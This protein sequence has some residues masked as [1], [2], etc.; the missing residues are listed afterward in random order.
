[1]TEQN[2]PNF[3]PSE[4]SEQPIDDVRPLRASQPWE[5]AT[6]LEQSVYNTGYNAA[7]SLFENI[8]LHQTNTILV[9][10]HIQKSRQLDKAKK[11]LLE[12]QEL[13]FSSPVTSLPNRNAFERELQDRID[14]GKDTAVGVVDVT[15]LKAVNDRYGH[16]VGDDVLRSTAELLEASIILDQN[17]RHQDFVAH[18][19]GDEFAIIFDMEPHEDDAMSSQDRIDAISH[20][21]RDRMTKYSELSMPKELGVDAAIGIVLH[22]PNKTAV[23]TF[24]A[25]DAE[26]YKH[27]TVQHKKTGTT[28]R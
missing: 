23:E 10:E 9:D 28:P 27:K 17:T 19:H 6:A 20:N 16:V 21:F 2:P 18:L 15:N 12:A 4:S 22:D 8:T 14:K 26:M 1:M 25:A 7:K 24:D 3:E 13:A 11:E 5:G